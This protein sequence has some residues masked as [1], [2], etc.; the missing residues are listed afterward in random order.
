[1]HTHHG[2]G[3]GWAKHQVCRIISVLFLVL[4][5]PVTQCLLTLSAATTFGIL[6]TAG[7]IKYLAN[8]VL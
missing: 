1:M 8:Y 4:S 2:A 3:L 6:D 7:N 5:S